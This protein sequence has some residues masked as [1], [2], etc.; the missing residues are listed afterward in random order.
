MLENILSKYRFPGQTDIQ[1]VYEFFLNPPHTDDGQ[2]AWNP[3]KT[4]KLLRFL[5]KEY[6]FSQ[7][8]AEKTVQRLRASFDKTS[9]PGAG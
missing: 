4:D 7:E 9:R 5:V 1:G 2:M 8:R 3:P 6:D